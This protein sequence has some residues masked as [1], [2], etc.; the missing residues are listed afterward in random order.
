MSEKPGTASRFIETGYMPKM[1]DEGTDARLIIDQIDAYIAILERGLDQLS[2]RNRTLINQ[3]NRKG[4][5][6]ANLQRKLHQLKVELREGQT[7]S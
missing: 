1:P 7:P 6:I 5:T 2:K 4:T 3:C